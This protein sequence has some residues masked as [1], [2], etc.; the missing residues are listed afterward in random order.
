MPGFSGAGHTEVVTGG[1]IDELGH[2]VIN[3]VM[4]SPGLRADRVWG[5]RRDHPEC[6]RM[7][8][9]HA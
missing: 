6:G 8:D 1:E 4:L 3:H 9:H 5:S 2:Q 7:S